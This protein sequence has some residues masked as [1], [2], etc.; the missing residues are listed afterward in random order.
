M[1]RDLTGRRSEWEAGAWLAAIVSSSEDAIVSMD[2]AGTLTTW[3]PGAERL[4]GYS[5]DEVHGKPVARLVPTRLR[6]D[7][8][9]QMARVRGG[10]HI[11]TRDTVRLHKNGHEIEVAE[12]L[13]LIRE[14]TGAA[15]GISAVLRDITERKQAER[16]LRRLL[17]DGQRRERWLG[18]ISEVRL[19]MLA[20]GGLAQW[21]ALIARRASEL[22]DADG[23]TVSVVAKN[24]HTR[25]EVI[26]T[27]GALV[28]PWRGK[29]LSVSD[30]AAGR[31]F[32]SGRSTV[33]DRPLV[34]ARR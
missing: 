30:S 16:E 8:E 9:E 6:A 7:M 18:S 27:H 3:N 4:L 15:T 20:G 24:D 29:S 23:I 33:T 13:S 25:L 2:M 22:S 12:A 1:V 34:G 28:A 10:M 31:V 14:P 5:A 19:S 32:T 11:P 17:V 26:A 21:L